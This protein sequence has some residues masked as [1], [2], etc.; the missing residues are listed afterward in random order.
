MCDAE[1]RLPVERARELIGMLEAR[2]LTRA[3]YASHLSWGHGNGPMQKML[4]KMVG[5]P[6]PL[7]DID[8][9]F[10]FV[11]K[12]RTQLLAILRK[13]IE[14]NEPLVVC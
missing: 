3:R 9:A 10:A 13:S 2:P 5:E 8:E 12:K 6:T 14:L 7:P 4:D 1:H 11:S